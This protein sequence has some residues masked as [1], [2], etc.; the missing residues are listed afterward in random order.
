MDDLI[1]SF[2]SLIDN[3]DKQLTINR[4]TEKIRGDRYNIFRVI[5]MTSNETSVHSAFIA[6]LL[7]PNGRHECNN[8]FLS[9]FLSII[10]KPLCHHF[11]FE[12]LN[13]SVEIEKYIGEKNETTGGRLDIIIKDVFGKSIIIENKIYAEDQENQLVRYHNYGTSTGKDFLL[14]YLTLD[15]HDATIKS[16]GNLTKNKEYYT[17]SYRKDIVEWLNNCRELESC[18]NLNMLHSGIMH[19]LKLVEKLTH[20]D[21]NTESMNKLYDIVK[22]SP[23][24]VSRI[25]DYIEALYYSRLKLT[26][27]FW[28]QVAS[29]IINYESMCGEYSIVTFKGKD[30]E[31]HSESLNMDNLQNI[32]DT[33]SK[34]FKTAHERNNGYSYRFGIQIPVCKPFYDSKQLMLGLI[35]DGLVTLRVYVVDDNHLVPVKDI[36]K[37]IE[38]L[39]VFKAEHLRCQWVN[40]HKYFLTARYLSDKKSEWNFRDMP[41]DTLYQLSNMDEMVTNTVDT[42]F[43][44]IGEIKDNIQEIKDN[45]EQL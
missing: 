42:L 10:I 13:A 17:I 1:D 16:K 22:S 37:E 14:L 6:D 36:N 5:N 39:S 34:E 35:V 23:V 29:R 7:N 19:Y 41:N 28:S 4:E 26:H 45:F 18:K 33:Y 9:L 20:T 32:I 31:Y 11:S 3:L 38:E 43:K 44:Y 2:G 27:E 8:S 15:G 21:M 24:Y 30:N 40:D 25:S 12:V